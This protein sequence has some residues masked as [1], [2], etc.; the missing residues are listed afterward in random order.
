MPDVMSRGRTD[1]PRHTVLEASGPEAGHAL[2]MANA[3]GGPRSPWEG[4]G[5]DGLGALT[6]RPPTSAGS[7]VQSDVR[8]V[9]GGTRLAFA[10]R[11]GLSDLDAVRHVAFR[12]GRFTPAPDAWSGPPLDY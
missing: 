6:R 7:G 10:G 5:G 4:P 12:P 8:N 1:R 11:S 3:L 2:E 9:P